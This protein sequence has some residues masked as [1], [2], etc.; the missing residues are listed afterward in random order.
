MLIRGGTAAALSS[1][2]A[3]CA[4]AASPTAAPTKPAA[5]APSAAGAGPSAAAAA[6]PTAAPSPPPTAASPTAGASAPA[7]S[8]SAGATAA[9]G[10]AGA[11]TKPA[12]GATTAAPSAGATTA[13]AAGAAGAAA[14]GET[15]YVFN[16]ASKD[17]TLIDAASR[18]VKSTKPLGAQVRWLSN[19]QTFSDGERIWTYDF[20]DNKVQ[21]IAIDPKEIALTKTIKDLG[22]GPA[23]S[24]VVLPDKKKAAVNI[25]GDNVVALVDLPSGSV[26]A[27]I[28]TGAFP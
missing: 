22:T 10:V 15:V 14:G 13:P 7:T 12:A 21:V 20:P 17:V 9:P 3:A 25:A 11:A 19:E 5:P 23:H 2:V 16:V 8:A 27:K 26:E 6:S 4:P 24:V 1:L 18:Q 28:K